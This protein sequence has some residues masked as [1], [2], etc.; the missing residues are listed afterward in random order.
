MPRKEGRKIRIQKVLLS[1]LTVWMLIFFSAPAMAS[2][3]D[4]STTVPSQHTVTVVCNAHGKV[5][6]NG[7]E[8]AGTNQFTVQRHDR[9]ALTAVPDP[10]YTLASISSSSAG[11]MI[12]SGD[13]AVIDRV[14]GDV[15]ITIAFQQKSPPKPPRPTPDTDSD[16][17]SDWD[18]G[19]EATPTPEPSAPDTPASPSSPSKPDSS[20]AAPFPSGTPSPAPES[21]SIVAPVI[22]EGKQILAEVEI[23]GGEAKIRVDKGKLEEL[24]TADGAAAVKIDLSEVDMDINTA[25]IPIDTV[26]AVVD[27]STSNGLGVVLPHAAVA[28]D[29]DALHAIVGQAKADAITIH[30]EEIEEERLGPAQQAALAQLP[31]NAILVEITLSSGD[32]LIR[33]FQG[34]QAEIQVP[35]VP[36]TGEDTAAITVWNIAE[37]GTLEKVACRYEDG[38]V[39]FTVHHFSHYLIQPGTITAG[40]VDSL[41]PPRESGG[42]KGVSSG[43]MIG[44]VLVFFLC[45]CVWRRQ[46]NKQ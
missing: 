43:L 46:K 8:Y 29:V 41:E 28:F 39:F 3:I 23:A 19:S 10:D 11:G 34:G 14:S 18:S 7:I 13:G 40:G 6:I 32:I 17:D 12:L 42:S 2:G 1:L 33:D 37:D 31:G 45:W 22:G 9:F 16:S 15:A 24:L 30:V 35:Y 26:Q 38:F 20:I 25:V 5:L 36:Q 4:I 27:R 44:L 21:G